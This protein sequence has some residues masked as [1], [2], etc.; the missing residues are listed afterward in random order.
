MSSTIVQ[1]TKCALRWFFLN[2]VDLSLH[3]NRV[4]VYETL[5]KPY[6]TG[7]AIVFDNN[8]VLNNMGLVGGEPVSLLLDSGESTYSA[9]MHVLAVKGEA[10]ATSMRTQVYTIDL[11]SREYFG[12][13]S[14]L[15]QQAFK[16]V[17]GTG[18]IQSIHSRFVGTP[19][20]VL[21]GSSGLLWQKNS[22]VVSSLKPFKAI[23]D[24][25]SMLNF[26]SYPSGT[27]V[28]YRDAA[29][30]KLAPLEHLLDNMGVQQEFVQEATWGKRLEDMVRAKWAII[31]AAASVNKDGTGRVGLQN[32]SARATQERKVFDLFSNHKMF[33]VAARAMSGAGLGGVMPFAGALFDGVPGGHGGSHNYVVGDREKIPAANMRNTDQDQMLQAQVAS[34]PQLTIKVPCQSGFRCTVGKG[35]FARLLPPV[36]DDQSQSPWPEQNGGQM[37]VVDLMHEAYLDDR[38][39]AATTT[40]RLVKG[41]FG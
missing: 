31:E 8:N 11:I 37:L 34:S 36:G 30:S 16:S 29:G 40:M 21:V 14:N 33:D 17:T 1:P 26:D 6:L 24:I 4:R 15:V 22:H 39:L 19:L 2:G 41:R 3:V 23:N 7:Q 27:N 9:E 10:S 18:A 35:V 5:C 12:D 13:R 38:G 20:D 32:V 25:R 28:Y